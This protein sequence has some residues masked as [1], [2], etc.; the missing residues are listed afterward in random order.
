[1][2]FGRKNEEKPSEY[3]KKRYKSIWASSATGCLVFDDS[4]ITEQEYLD[5]IVKTVNKRLETVDEML[6]AIILADGKHFVL[7]HQNNDYDQ[8]M[9]DLDPLFWDEDECYCWNDITEVMQDKNY[10]LIKTYQNLGQLWV[11]E[12]RKKK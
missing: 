3:P 8:V 7:Q 2:I 4:V 6:E 1:M 5:D 11:K 10:R 12:S 9:K